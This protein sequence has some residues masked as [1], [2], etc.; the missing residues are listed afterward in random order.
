MEIKIEKL[1]TRDEEKDR[2][3]ECL[4]IQLKRNGYR[5][6]KERRKQKNGRT[7]ENNK[8]GENR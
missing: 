1:T 5:R 8:E 7:N 4:W 6:K 3:K 2:L